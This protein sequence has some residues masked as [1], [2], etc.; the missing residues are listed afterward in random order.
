MVV[1]QLWIYIFQILRL[2]PDDE[3]NFIEYLFNLSCKSYD[4]FVCVIIG[5]LVNNLFSIHQYT[6][7]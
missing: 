2:G 1:G 7:I 3:P 4:L 5:L 6:Y